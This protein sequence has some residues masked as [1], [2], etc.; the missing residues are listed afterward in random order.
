[1]GVKEVNL[2]KKF[3]SLIIEAQEKFPSNCLKLLE[4]A[5]QLIPNKPEPYLFLAFERVQNSL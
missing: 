2:S 1:M 3:N 4:E 5:S